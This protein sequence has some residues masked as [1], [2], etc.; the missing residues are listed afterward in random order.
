MSTKKDKKWSAKKPVLIGLFA[1]AALVGGFGYWSVVANISGAVVASGQIQVEQNRQVVQHP[2][3]GVI[4]KILVKEGDT[5]KAEDVLIT[6]DPTRLHSELVVIEG[7][8]F[9]YL[10]RRGRLEAERDEADSI[11]FD[12]LLASDHTL[13]NKVQGLKDGQKRLFFARR[14]TLAQSIEQLQ[15][16]RLQISEQIKGL[17]SQQ[18]AMQ[19]QLGLI[20]EELA[21]QQTLYDK[22]LAQVSRIL[23][24]RREEARMLGLVGNLTAQKA[25]AE[26][27]ITELDIQVLQLSTSRREEAITALRDLQFNELKLREQRRA[28]QDQL[29]RLEIRAPVSGIVYGLK[30]FAPRSVVRPADPLMYIIPQDRPLVIAA[31][32]A[33]IHIDEVFIGQ[34][35][36]LLFASLDSRTTP[37]LRGRVITISP[38]VFV[39]QNSMQS[40]YNAKIALLDGEVEKLPSGTELIPG[41][42]VEA[43]IRTSDRSPL[44]YLLKPLANYF[45]KAFR[46]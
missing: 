14:K 13:D 43:F 31:K 36:S 34:K 10:A 29:Q 6:L 41:M 11:S 39:D 16:R 8:L 4:D 1:L 35:V 28:L 7:Q 17:V 40:F 2:D 45:T 27:R 18:D 20:S 26:G 23:A 44:E 46:E 21:A 33:T 15:K 3:G 19:T 38:D 37:K 42:P 12:P 5:V 9:E 32:I 24:L 25:Q 22:G 30:F